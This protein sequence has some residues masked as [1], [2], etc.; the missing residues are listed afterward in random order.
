MAKNPMQRKAQNS[1]LL[2][3]LI[4]LLITGLIIAFLFL[5][6]TNA[7]KETKK[8]IGDRVKVCVLNTD[9]KSGQVITDD[10]VK[11]LEVDRNTIP[12]NSFGDDVSNLSTYSLTDIAGNS[13]R[14]DTNGNLCVP[15]IDRETGEVVTN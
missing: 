9:V 6:L 4:T 11:I 12:S 15:Y 1:F 5:Q 14:T 3:M 2:G 13:V 10:L 7:Q 8:L